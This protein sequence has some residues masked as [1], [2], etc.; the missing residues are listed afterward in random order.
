MRRWVGSILTL[1]LLL[2][3]PASAQTTQPS[4]TRA[5]ARTIGQIALGELHAGTAPGLAVGVV[6]D[7]RIVYAQ[8]FGFADLAHHRRVRASTEFY[9]GSITKQ[10]TAASILL[11]VQSKMLALSDPL[12][13]Y[14]PELTIAKDVTIL[15]L[16][17]QTSGLPDYTKAPGISHDQTRPIAMSAL[18]KAVD[19]MPMAS[20]PGSTFQYNNFNYMLLGLVVARASHVP[21]S[22]YYE[23]HIFEPLL[24]TSTF[25]AGDQ[26][27]S[28]LH[29]VGYTREG[30]AFVPAKP[31]DPSWLFGAGSLVTNVYDLAKWDIELPLLL[32]VDSMREMWTASGAP[33]E[34]SYGMGWVIDQRGGRRFIWHN[35]EIAGYHAMNA[36]L[37]DAHV[38]VIVLTNVDGL[39]GDDVASP[40]RIAGRILDVVAPL[41]PA[42]FGNVL[43]ERAR[44]WLGRIARDD[45]DRT[46]LTPQFSAYLTDDLVHRAHFERLGKI[47]SLTPVES[48]PQAGGTVYVFLVRFAHGTFDYKFGLTPQGKI[49]EIL[50][51]PPK[52]THV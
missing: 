34:L 10:F 23:T 6:E 27:I 26:G 28:P 19:A 48:Y 5:M 2:A 44:E 52:P 9:V 1:A 3:A 20:K 46:Q 7:G 12:T 24:M 29:A 51:T 22:V 33:G 37:P 40:E 13:K 15:E 45:I 11:L 25:A 21:L 4:F 32:D 18:I 16:L 14:V 38:A 42:H 43:V 47:L 30:R 31:W 41:P 50:L 49:D 17:Q 35:G 39:H 36:L 8:G